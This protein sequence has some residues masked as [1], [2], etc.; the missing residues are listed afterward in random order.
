M[1][2]F[3]DTVQTFTSSGK[4]PST[5]FTPNLA[6]SKFYSEICSALHFE[7]EAVKS[8]SKTRWHLLCLPVCYYSSVPC[9]ALMRPLPQF[10]GVM[11]RGAELFLCPSLI[12]HSF[13]NCSNALQK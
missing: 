3:F 1:M 7:T 6:Q 13:I 2:F 10:Q 11:Q 8:P 5:F 9:G 4:I 12:D